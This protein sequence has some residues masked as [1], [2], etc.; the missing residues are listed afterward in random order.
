[1]ALFDPDDLVA[2]TLNLGI[3]MRYDEHGHVV[4]LDEFADTVFAFLL[5]HE[6]ADRQHFVYHEYFGNDH[7]CDG[8][9]DA[10]HHA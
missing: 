6:V 2:Q 9:G 3:A 8:E 10:G 4:F 7:R 1:M 5:E